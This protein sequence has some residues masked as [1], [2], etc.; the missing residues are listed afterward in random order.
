M[1]VV[2]NKIDG[3]K[4]CLS[5]AGNFKGYVDTVVQCRAHCVMECIRFFMQSH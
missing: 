5:N 3:N 2:E 1:V 4:K